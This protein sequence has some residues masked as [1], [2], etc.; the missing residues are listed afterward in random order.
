M[1]EILVFRKYS[2]I[3]KE[4]EKARGIQISKAKKEVK[5]VPAIKGR[6]P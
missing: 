4:L 6:A 1:D 5:R 2:A 3:N